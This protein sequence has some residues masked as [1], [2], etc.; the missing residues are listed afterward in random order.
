MFKLSYVIGFLLFAAICMF[1]CKTDIEI[2]DQSA[3]ESFYQ[4]P[5]YFPEMVFPEGN[6]F[7]NARWEF[8]KMLF[9]DKRLSIN[10]TISCATCHKQEFG[11]A[12][13]TPFSAGVFGRA[14]I[15]NVPSLANIGY[16]PYFLREGGVPT[17]EQQVLVPIQEHNEFNNDI[18]L[19]CQELN[20][21]TTYNRLAAEN[22]DRSFDP[23]VLTRAISLYQ[24][25]FISGNSAYDQHEFQQKKVL[26]AS[27]LRGKDLFFNSQN[28]C[29]TCHSGFNFTDYSFKNNGL[30]LNYTNAGRGR[31]TT[32]A[33]DSATFKVPSLRNIELTAPYMHDGSL[34][35]L[36]GVIDH[37]NSG[38]V[39]HPN[40]SSLIKPLGLT[41][42]EK[43]DLI[44]F[45][46]SLTDYEFVNDVRF[47]E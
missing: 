2:A 4:K 41:N 33:I 16:N 43:E 6:E 17:L 45:L 34:A 29:G 14:G 12:D 8:G 31:V 36:E 21:D 7:T 3:E 5:D 35:T 44:A 38:G 37:Y 19:L 25:T 13:N 18:V 15:S 22:Y 30:Y 39:A 47:S 28:Q 26:N 42:Q 40:K 10:N 32:N 20:L 11:L 9:F 27:Q 46:T 1:S 24:R 23:F